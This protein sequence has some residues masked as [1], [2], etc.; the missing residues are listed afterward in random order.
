MFDHFGIPGTS[1][2]LSPLPIPVDPAFIIGSS[3]TQVHMS[4]AGFRERFTPVAVNS[5]FEAL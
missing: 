3:G 1:G 2:N 5:G 4:V